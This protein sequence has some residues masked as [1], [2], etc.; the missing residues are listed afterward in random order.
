LLAES[1]PILYAPVG[2]ITFL[3]KSLTYFVKNT[4]AS[5]LIIKDY[6][7]D[8]QCKGHF[9]CSCGSPIWKSLL[10]KGAQF[11]PSMNTTDTAVGLQDRIF[12]AKNGGTIQTLQGGENKTV[13]A[14][15]IRDGKILVTGS[16]DEVKAEFPDID[17][18]N[19]K[20]IQGAMTLLPAFI[21]PHVHIIPTAVVNTGTD[22][23]PFVGQDLR[24]N[25]GGT[26]NQAWVI[27]ALQ[28][29]ATATMNK[30]S[31][32]TINAQP[33]ADSINGAM[34]YTRQFTPTKPSV[35]NS[36]SNNQSWVLGHNVDPSLL[37][38]EHKEFNATVLDKVKIEV[39]GK[40]EDANLP[41]MVINTSGH[42]AY[43]NQ[44]TI[45]Q[46]AEYNKQVA[47]Y[48]EDHNSAPIT[49]GY[50]NPGENGI[51]QEFDEMLPVL[52]FLCTW[53][54]QPSQKDITTEVSHIFETASAR[55][56]TY[57]LDASL[58]DDQLS[59]LKSYIAINECPVRIGGAYLV[60]SLEQLNSDIIGV[61]QPNQG[62]ENLNVAYLKLVSDGSAQGLTAYQYTPYDCDE[63][64]INFSLENAAA[65]P[66]QNNTGLFNY[67]YPLEFNALVHTANNYGWPVMIHAN[68]DHAIDRTINAFKAAGISASTK[69][70]R[71]D[72]I[73]H[74]SLLSAKN[75][76]DMERL[77]I[78]PSFTI[79][80]VGYWGWGFQNSIIGE[81]RVAQLDLCRSAIIEH[82]MRI[83]LNSDYGVTP[84]GPLRMMEQ[85]ITRL[86][87]STPNGMTQQVLN[88][89][90]C[91]TP[92][93]ALKAMTY[94]AAWQ[95]HAE[96][97]VGSLEAGKCADFIILAESPL[98]YRNQANLTHPAQGMRNIP[99]LETW[100]G[101]KKVHSGTPNP[102][103]TSLS[104]VQ[105][106]KEANTLFFNYIGPEIVESTANNTHK[107][108]QI[109]FKVL[110][111]AGS[112]KGVQQTARLADVCHSYELPQ[113]K[114]LD[115]TDILLAGPYLQKES[116][117]MIAVTAKI[118]L[119]KTSYS[120]AQ[121]TCIISTSLDIA[122]ATV[123]FTLPEL[124]TLPTSGSSWVV[125]IDPSIDSKG[126]TTN[127]PLFGWGSGQINPSGENVI[128]Y[129]KLTT[130]NQGPNGTISVTG[131]TTAM[132]PKIGHLYRIGI[133]LGSNYRLSAYQDL[134]CA[135]TITPL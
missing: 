130:L 118:Q 59:L 36:S 84:M 75:M 29:A 98:T 72:R 21:E 47:D 104:N 30:A 66:D 81:K 86:M 10:P 97:W 82:N 88:A 52:N 8:H 35:N 27:G 132:L 1:L 65:L 15:G 131:F 102:A 126:A 67:G 3:S 121:S 92:F 34:D 63:N 53:F 93:Q 68:G 111:H 46:I 39:N 96:Q 54:G 100:K 127:N 116:A 48:N 94:D 32:V 23:S 108:G 124:T 112:I 18:Q 85:S 16:I 78:S 20:L 90:E 17:T 24:V 113:G 120:G 44:Y 7:M 122:G 13:E 42:L 79:G 95:C 119:N 125:V 76:S 49:P 128:F 83:T 45:D 41:I 101:G 11:T 5:N 129:K 26:Y 62:D 58:D 19:I 60:S 69:E 40:L 91:I 38:G 51:L 73:E 22:L 71:R 87:E 74:C 57:M 110:D 123:E 70:H 43:I 106:S 115:K 25:T 9:S 103:T 64:Y 33:N 2:V 135:N 117:D 6:M 77:G 114:T 133:C 105:C 37:N 28:V 99:I 56:V 14:I 50:I 107:E 80:H 55:G 4:T 12:Q 134:T 89:S 109:W 61:H 31:I